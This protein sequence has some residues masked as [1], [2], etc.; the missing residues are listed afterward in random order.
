M[1][2]CNRLYINITGNL[3]DVEGA[4]QCHSSYQGQ[5]R[6]IVHS[7]PEHRLTVN[8]IQDIEWDQEALFP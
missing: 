7:H 8:Q 1:S 3:F 2:L 5:Q 6:A 4:Q